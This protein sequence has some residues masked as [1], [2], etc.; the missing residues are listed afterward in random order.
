MEHFAI[1][2][3]RQFGSLGRPI[4][5]KLSHILNIEYYDR[6]I[7][8][9]TCK[10][11]GYSIHEVSDLE[12]NVKSDYLYMKWP[13]GRVTSARQDYIFDVQSRFIKKVSE[14]ENCIIVGRCSDFI[15][16]ENPNIMRIFIYAPYAERLKNCTDIL[17]IPREKAFRMIDSVDKAR[18][19]YHRRYAGYFPS[20]FNHNDFLINSSFLGVDGTA[21]YIAKLAREKF[22][23]LMQKSADKPQ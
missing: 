18:N 22:S 11:T 9:Y 8:D 21:E 1:T 12:E 2:I 15:L 3:N 4:A 5:Q 7:V 6:D 16:R 14:K 13:L 10:D 17:L 20:D 19:S 23:S